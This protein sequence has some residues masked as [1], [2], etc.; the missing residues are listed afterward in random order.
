MSKTSTDAPSI[1]GRSVQVHH[2]GL[3]GLRG[4]AVLLVLVFHSGLGWLPGGFLGVSLFFTLSGY[5]IVNLLLVEGERTGRI[6]LTAFWGRRLRRLAPASLMV[7]AATVGFATWLSTSVEADRVRG[8]A[9]SALAYVA[10]W[11][12][13]TAGQ[14]YDQLFSSPSPLQHLW[15]LS[16]EEQM[17][18][19]VPFVVA[20]VFVGGGGRR[21]LGFIFMLGTGV[22]VVASV[23][24]TRHDIVYYGTHTR[25]GELLLGAVLACFLG[26]RWG[27]FSKNIARAWSSA[28]LAAVGLIILLARTTDVGSTWVYGGSLVAFAALSV[29]AVVGSIVPGF[30]AR[31]LGWSP[32]VW[33]GRISYGLY[34]VHWPI[35]VWLNEERL[36][37]GGAALFAVQMSAS[38]VVA[39]LSYRMIEMPIRERRVLRR[40]GIAGFTFVAVAVGTFAISITVL[41]TVEATPDSDVEVLATVPR[42]STIAPDPSDGVFD[43]SG[44]VNILVIGDSTAENIARGLADVGDPEIGVISGGVLGCPLLPATRVRDSVVGEQDVTYCPDVEKLV[45]ESAPDVDVVFVVVGLANQWDYLPVGGEE[46]IDAGSSEQRAALDG[47]MQT[48]QESLSP[49]DVSTLV[50]EAPSVRDNPDLL[51]DDPD[52]IAAWAQVIRA[53]DERWPLVGVVAY[54]DLLSDPYGEAGRIERPDGVHLDRE[55]AR[56]LARTSLIPRIRSAWAEV[57]NSINSR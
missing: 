4:I 36:G 1:N 7:I 52:A 11:R 48:M 34:L 14:T 38:A 42:T 33:V 54:A 24:T 3:D 19:I 37:F 5:L 28:G 22:S 27:S 40:P 29:I 51:G 15:S 45:L 53:W 50:L 2:R 57:R 17:Y 10:N 9:A 41:S 20:L 6:N 21:A 18:L 31:M 8:D 55:F 13:V 30:T 12:F 44:P 23:L 56:E 32:L 39:L 25:A 16:I 43:G 47:L 46:W 35:I 26:Q 49:F